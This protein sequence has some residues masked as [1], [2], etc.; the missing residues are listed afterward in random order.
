MQ[1]E[2]L[3]QSQITLPDEIVVKFNISKGDKLEL[4]EK[5]G[6]ICLLPKIEYTQKK[7]ENQWPRDFLNTLGSFEEI[8]IFEP[9]ELSFI[10]DVRREEM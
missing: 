4:F 7:P 1:I 2:M 3:T 8:D 5:D 9:E 6:L 10:H